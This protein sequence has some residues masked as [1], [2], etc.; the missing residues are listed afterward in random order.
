MILQQFSVSSDMVVW[1]SSS[2]SWKKFLYDY[3]NK[4][5]DLLF[6]LNLTYLHCILILPT[7]CIFLKILYLLFELILIASLEKIDF[8]DGIVFLWYCSAARGLINHMLHES[9]KMTGRKFSQRCWI[10]LL[11]NCYKEF[12]DTSL[13]LGLGCT[14]SFRY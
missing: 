8:T 13:K 14:K 10:C 12:Q 5:F 9:E 7:W 4:F 2:C 3:V 11:A 1:Y 6:L